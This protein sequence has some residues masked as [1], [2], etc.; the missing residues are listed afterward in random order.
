MSTDL[1]NRTTVRELVAVFAQA[2]AEIRAAFASIVAVEERLNGAFVPGDR[3]YR[4][5]VVSACGMRYHDDFKDADESIRILARAA[6][7]RIAERY[8]LRRFMSIKRWE[9]FNR[10]VDEDQLPPITEEHV[11]GFLHAQLTQAR[12][13]LTEA[14]NEV[15]EWLRPR[16]YT[17]A[18]Q[19]KTNT[20][21]EIGPK[22]ILPYVV[23]WSYGRFEV[24][25]DRRQH[26]VALENVFRA[27]DGRG[28]IQGYE[29]EIETAIKASP[30]GEGETDLFK[31]RC[32][33]NRNLHLAFRRPDL[34]ARFNAVAGGHRLRPAETDEERLRR[35]VAKARAENE[36]LKRRAAQRE[37]A[38]ASPGGAPP[39]GRGHG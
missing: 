36:R 34:L 18:G 24:D 16:R 17:R 14:V 1:V 31:F 22:V 33:R 29:P 13:H 28:A 38:T 27:L 21:L 20:E 10:A 3:R 12:D 11:M 2:E 9:E 15:F 25:Y 35:E 39:P 7:Y 23:R 19:L 37:G 6:W 26:L 32:C 8:E 5:F 4:T 30:D